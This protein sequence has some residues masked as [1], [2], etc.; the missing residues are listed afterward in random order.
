MLSELPG[1][2]KAIR[3]RDI[4]AARCTGGRLCKGDAIE[5]I[6]SREDAFHMNL[7]YSQFYAIIPASSKQDDCC[8]KDDR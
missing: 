5:A 4:S 8:G 1:C 3:K 2:D 6:S 7:T